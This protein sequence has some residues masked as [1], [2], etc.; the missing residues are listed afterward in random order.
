MRILSK[1]SVF[2]VL[3][4]AIVAAQSRP[5]FEVAS[6]KPNTGG[7]NRMMLGMQPGGGI[8][9]TN[10]PLRA[11]V[12]WA[13]QLQDFQLVGAPEWI[14][15]ERF[16]I[17]AKATV[18]G[19]QGQPSEAEMRDVRQRMQSL[20][21][22]RFKLAAHRETRPLPV[23]ALVLARP[24]GKLGPQLRPS[25]VDCAAMAGRGRQAGPM[26]P[27]APGERPPCGMMMRPGAIAA[28]ATTIS[29]LIQPLSMFTHRTVIDHT[30]LK[31][32]FDIDLSF[33]PD[34]M[35]AGAPP[36][37][38]AAPP[39]DP[40]GPSIFTAL[41]EQLGLKLESENAPVEVLVID[42]VERPTPD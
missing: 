40:N 23:Y 35:P 12:T 7:D 31:G 26:A 36:P 25:T 11:L 19:V 1:V 14:D 34:Q 2:C 20:L 29:Q 3:A 5:S 24:D 17:T 41:Q 28:G 6:V 39:I 42:R 10:M 13:Y 21:E 38:V 22:E 4:C 16:N 9:A 33:T 8:T 27:P 37:G 18:E 32:N 15:N 30:G